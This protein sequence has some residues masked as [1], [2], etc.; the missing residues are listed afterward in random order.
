MVVIPLF[1]MGAAYKAGQMAPNSDVVLT[2]QVWMAA[3]LTGV[4]GCKG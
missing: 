2:S 3:A 1:F 4:I